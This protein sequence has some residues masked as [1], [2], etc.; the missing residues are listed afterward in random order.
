MDHSAK[1]ADVLF[2]FATNEK[3]ALNGDVAAFHT[4]APQGPHRIYSSLGDFKEGRSMGINKIGLAG[5]WAP[6]RGRG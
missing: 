6:C 4:V 3:T 1:A 2:K 5:H